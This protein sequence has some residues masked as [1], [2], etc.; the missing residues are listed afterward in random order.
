MP[1]RVLLQKVLPFLLSSIAAALMCSVA[2]YHSHI[3]ILSLE[4]GNLYS[5]NAHRVAA[6]NEDVM[7]SLEHLGTDA[8]VFLQIDSAP[9]I[10]LITARDIRSLSIPFHDGEGF[11]GADGEALVGSQARCPTGYRRVGTLGVT[12]DSMLS[13][14]VLLVDNRSFLSE[15]GSLILD[16]S[17][18][19][20]RFEYL[21]PEAIVEQLSESQRSFGGTDVLSPLIRMIGVLLI[22]ILSISSGYIFG[23][24]KIKLLR[25]YDLLGLDP[26]RRGAAFIAG[27]TLLNCATFGCIGAFLHFAGSP[28]RFI[29]GETV[30]V[31][32]AAA[33]ALATCTATAILLPRGRWHTG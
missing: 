31:G 22:A 26:Y 7:T 17:N 15:D 24:D 20:S 29:D 3:Q 30:I 6:S 10:R 8:R 19:A 16:G 25:T 9:H 27:Y 14:Q 28:P 33:V 5:E 21:H 23:A 1:R 18:A 2:L 4:F 13:N 12:D 32:T 11:S